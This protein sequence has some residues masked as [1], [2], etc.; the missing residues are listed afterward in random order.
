MESSPLHQTLLEAQQFAHSGIQGAGE[1]EEIWT[2]M[3]MLFRLRDISDAFAGK[4]KE[5]RNTGDNWLA[6]EPHRVPQPRPGTLP[7]IL[8]CP[9]FPRISFF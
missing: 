8:F 7:L 6:V 4:F 1:E 3:F 2:Y 9:F 5:Q